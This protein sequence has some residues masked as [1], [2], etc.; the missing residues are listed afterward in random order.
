MLFA[1]RYIAVN[2]FKVLWLIPPLGFLWM[3]AWMTK[4]PLCQRLSWKKLPK[5]GED[6]GLRFEQARS[7][8]KFGT[9]T[10]PIILYASTADGCTACAT[11][12]YSTIISGAR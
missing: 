2:V 4:H 9:L 3:L 6:L 11:L 12:A 1:L 8:S 5:A 10:C 7:Y